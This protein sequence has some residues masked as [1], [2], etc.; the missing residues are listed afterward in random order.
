MSL[1]SKDITISNLKISLDQLLAVI[2]QLDEPVRIQIA[3]ALMETEMDD[4]LANLIDQLAKT[5]PIDDISDA[6]I[7]SEIKTVRQMN[8]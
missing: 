6:D 1:Q 5:K 2:R 8:K 7:D 3:K 4:R